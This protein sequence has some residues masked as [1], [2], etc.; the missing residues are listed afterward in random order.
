MRSDLPL[1]IYFDGSCRVC[2]G[3]M[4]NIKAHDGRGYLRLVD[5]SAPDFDE[6]AFRSEGIS[7]QDMMT[8]LHLRDNQGAWVTGAA[9]MELIYRTVGMQ[10]IASLWGRGAL[11]AKLYPWIA[12]NRQALS[13]TGAPLVFALWARLAAWRAYRRTRTCSDGNCSIE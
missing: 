8:R 11:L 12:R 9:A 5:C 10:R 3:E 4:M 7:R 2:Y 6:A 1:T 13:L